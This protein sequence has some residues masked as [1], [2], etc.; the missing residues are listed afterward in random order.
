[1]CHCHKDRHVDHE[2][3]LGTEII[4]YIYGLLIFNKGVKKF[5]WGNKSLFNKQC[6]DSLIFT[7]TR[8][9]LDPHF[10][11]NDQK[12]KLRAKII[13]MLEN[14]DLNLHDFGLGDSFLDMTSK[15]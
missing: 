4:P 11:K 3:E 1:M 9:N 15:A 5:K 7:C 6:W 8:M 10:T 12:L 13:K 14:I 2:T